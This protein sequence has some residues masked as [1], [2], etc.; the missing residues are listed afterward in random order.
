M[1]IQNLNRRQA[2]WTLYL[3]RFDFTLKHI[4]EI[5]MGKIDGLNRRLDQEIGIEK[6]NEN[7]IFIKDYW[8]HNLSEIVIKEPEVDIIEKIK[9]A[10]SKDKKVV[11]V[12]EKMKKA[13]VKVV[14]EDEQQLRRELVLKK[15]KIYMSK[16]GAL[17]VEIIQLHLAGYKEK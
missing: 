11:R 7:Q 3:S 4:P 12:V 1:K 9:I 17:R 5:K 16:N 8:L 10:R 6:D 15:G 2:K 13:G 14:Q